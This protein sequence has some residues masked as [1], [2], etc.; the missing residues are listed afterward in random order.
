VDPGAAK[1]A[2]RGEL[3][4]RLPAVAEHL[5]PDAISDLTA[6]IKEA[7]RAQAKELSDAA[8]TALQHVPRLLRGAAKR[9][10]LG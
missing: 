6:A 3:R 1:T 2:L 4:G 5:G 8:D 10:L 9:V 7:K